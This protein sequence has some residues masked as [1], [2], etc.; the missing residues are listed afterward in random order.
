MTAVP[1][2]Q[3]RQDP[4]DFLMGGGARS[5]KF[6]TVGQV[7]KGTI[8]GLDMQQQRDFKTQQPKYWDDGK[9]MM[10][11]RVLLATDERDPQAADDD[12]QRAVYLK[13]E[14][15]KAVKAAVVDA[16]AK[17]IEVGGILA[18]AFTGLGE[19]KGNLDPPKLYRAQYKPPV[20]VE[21]AINADDLI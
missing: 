15:Q 19:K 16:G 3:Q 7:A 4:N 5:F 21:N 11:L 20:P 13:G 1:Q 6:E 18:L 8:L 14:S 17:S 9:P 10:Q 12:G 2:Q